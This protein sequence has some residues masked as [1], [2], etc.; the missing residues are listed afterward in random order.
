VKRRAVLGSGTIITGSTPIY[1][2]PNERI[3][4]PQPG[5]PLV[6]PEAAVVVPGARQI[7]EGAG[8]RWG[9][10]LATPVIVKYR[11]DKTDSRIELERWIR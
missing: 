4:T 9:L 10:S 1:D 7:T 3:I 5:E 2:L 6:V 8:R 11:D